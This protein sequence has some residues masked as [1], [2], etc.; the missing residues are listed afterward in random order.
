MEVTEESASVQKEEREGKRETG[1]HNQTMSVFATEKWN[2]WCFFLYPEW[3]KAFMLSK[4]GG[5]FKCLHG[6][7]DLLFLLFYTG[8]LY[9]LRKQR[10]GKKIWERHD[11][12]ERLNEGKKKALDVCFFLVLITIGG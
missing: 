2:L 9:F 10:G 12:A 11:N 1:A 7:V 4:C 8:T 3:D 6:G 5:P